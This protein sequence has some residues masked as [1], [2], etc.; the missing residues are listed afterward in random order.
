LITNIVFTYFNKK[1]QHQFLERL[2]K[3]VQKGSILV[4]GSNV[5]IPLVRW[6]G[7][8]VNTHPVFKVA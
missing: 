5:N 8:V 3:R 6:L 7:R 2:E 1:N 4:T